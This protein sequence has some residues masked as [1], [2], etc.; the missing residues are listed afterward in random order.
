MSYTPFSVAGQVLLSSGKVPLAGHQPPPERQ[1]VESIFATLLQFRINRGPERCL[2]L[3]YEGIFVNGLSGL[4]GGG[5]K[6]GKIH[7]E[8]LVG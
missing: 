4:F 7:I 5:K 3:G 2:E 6:A 1:Y 8:M